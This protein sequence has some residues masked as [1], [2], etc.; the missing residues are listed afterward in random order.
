[1]AASFFGIIFGDMAAG[2]STHFDRIMPSASVY[3]KS[4]L[5]RN[6]DEYESV[7]ACADTDFFISEVYMAQIQ[8]RDLTFYYEGS[9]EVVFDHVSF[10]IDSN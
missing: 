9:P 6:D 2:L 3:M 5:F 8:I 4:F 10:S 1:M 7:S